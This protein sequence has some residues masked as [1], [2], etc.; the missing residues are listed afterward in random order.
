MHVNDSVG[1]EQIAYST[2][3]ILA[4]AGF[5]I[6]LAAADI[7]TDHEYTLATMPESW[8]EPRSKTGA[9]RLPVIIIHSSGSNTF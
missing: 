3:D 7:L 8:V 4:K 6:I 9:V 1:V 5:G 2:F